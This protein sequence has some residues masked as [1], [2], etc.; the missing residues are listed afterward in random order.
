MSSARDFKT[1]L[2]RLMC[3]ARETPEPV[4]ELSGC[5]LKAVPAGV[6]ILCKVLR[7]E[8]LDLRAN[9]LRSLADGGA[10]RDLVLLT[11]LDLSANAFQKLP[12]ELTEL[13]NL[14]VSWGEYARI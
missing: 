7:K 10:L 2:E 14:R 13:I 5:D 4:F 1:R 11:H 9:R 12:D 6:F 3:I 8:R